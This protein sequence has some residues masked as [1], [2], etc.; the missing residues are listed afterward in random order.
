MTC[1]L[2]TTKLVVHT[3]SDLKFVTQNTNAHLLWQLLQGSKHFR[4]AAKLKISGTCG[5]ENIICGSLGCDAMQ[6]CS[7]ARSY[8]LMICIS[9]KSTMG[10]AA[11][12][13][14]MEGEFSAP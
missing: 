3:L 9:N 12:E 6:Y 5:S 14:G 13:S 10:C 7:V 11:D 4:K 2:D 8:K 1:T